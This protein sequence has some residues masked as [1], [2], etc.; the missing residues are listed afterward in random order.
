MNQILPLKFRQTLL[1]CLCFVFFCMLTPSVSIAQTSTAP[2]T[3]DGTGTNP[4]QIATLDNLYWLSQTG[5]VWGSYF[6]QTAD[7]DATSSATW[8]NGKGFLPI[9]N[10]STPFNGTYNGQGHT[11]TGLTI[12][13]SDYTNVGL[14]GY[15]SGTVKNTGLIGSSIT[16]YSAVGSVVGYNVSTGTITNCYNSGTVSGN[17]SVGGVVGYNIGIITNCYNT[18]TVSGYQSSGGVDGYNIGT[19]A[20]CYN[21]GT[22]SGDHYLGGMV[23]QNYLYGTIT[24]CYNTGAVS[25]T[26]NYVGGI[27]GYNNVDAT[28]TNCFNTANV[29]GPIYFGGVAGG[30]SGALNYCY[31]NAT[32]IPISAGENKGTDNSIG[33]IATD[34][35]SAAFVTLLNAHRGDGNSSWLFVSGDYPILVPLIIA[36]APST[37]D[38]SSVNP[39]PIATL[40]NLY[41]LSQTSNVWSNSFIQTA[42]IDA[43]ATFTLDGGNGFSAIGN[44]TIKFTGTYNGQDY[45]IKGLTINRSTT[46]AVGLFGSLAGT[47][48]NCGLIG[49]SI[50]GWSSV[51]GVVGLNNSFG[52]VTNCYNTGAVNGQASV[53]GVAGTNNGNLTN[54]YNKGMVSGTADYVGGLTGTNNA[55][56]ITN[57]YNKGTISGTSA[58][59]GVAGLNSTGT[60]TNCYNSG[61]VSGKASAGGVVGYFTSGTLNYCY[62]NT[63]VYATGVGYNNGTNNSTGKTAAEMQSADFVTLL[64]ANKG[65]GNSSWVLVYGSYPTFGIASAITYNLNGGT[66]NPANTA[67]YTHGIGLIL[68]NPTQTDYVFDGWYDN[69]S[70]SGTPVLFISA[71]SIVDVALYAKWSACVAP[72][73]GDGTSTNPYQIATLG[74]LYWLSQ[75]NTVWD[76]SFI[77]IEDIN[78]ASTSIWDNGSG[79]S[80]IGNSKTLF[81]GTYNGQGHTITGLTVNRSSTDSIGFFGSLGTNGTVKNIRLIASSIKG[82]SYVGGVVGVNNGIL[83]YCHNTGTISGNIGKVG[84]VVGNNSSGTITNCYNTGAASGTNHGGVVG[85]NSGILNYCYWNTTI[86]ATGVGY[87]SGTNNSTGKTKIEMQSADFVTL[88]NAKK[89]DGNSSWILVSD[90]Y[91]VFGSTVTGIYTI[92]ASSFKIYPN[93]ATGY[94]IVQGVEK[95]TALLYDLNGRVVINQAI[96]GTTTINL[97]TLAKGI[98]TLYINGQTVKVI[99]Q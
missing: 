87:N 59:G 83:T 88:L 69:V 66:N 60:F 29:S 46:D 79:F 14:F 30:S 38:G 9:G 80:P 92:N 71:S 17:A 95:G 24:N 75:T 77:Q 56:T 55:G 91:P 94:I 70:L 52:T 84:G 65:D 13:R 2:K 47:V 35:Q 57:C 34:M 10:G 25:G 8:D 48:K 85:N 42:N 7:I 96:S 67:T 20:N 6:I 72:A 23:G 93:P 89:G 81:I 43:I 99:K 41:W 11:I 27:I 58:I 19:I 39:Y 78:A 90:G 64:N 50:I 86:Y 97:S 33:K 4:Y 22:V 21:T 51:G 68:S 62:W 31:W 37:G 18:G 54:C 98:Y 5:T 3:G 61:G 74:N 16:G 73:I 15:L 53:G 63:T 12:N 36:T 1:F 82:N 28:V 45:T 76:K 40:N 32:V 44:A 26:G 49:S